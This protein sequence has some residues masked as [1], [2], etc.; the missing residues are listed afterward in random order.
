MVGE[1]EGVGERQGDLLT[2]SV[3]QETQRLSG[4]F[5]ERGGRR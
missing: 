3:I 2:W 5:T 4:R 1:R